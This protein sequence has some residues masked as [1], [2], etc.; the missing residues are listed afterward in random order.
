MYFFILGRNPA[1]SIAEI[2]AVLARE[3]VD[4]KID[5]YSSEVLLIEAKEDLSR[6]FRELGG[7][8]KFGKIINSKPVVEELVKSLPPNGKKAFFGFS[9]YKLDD[10]VA[11]SDLRQ[12]QKETQKLAMEIKKFLRAKGQSA[13]F[14]VSRER[15][16]SSVIVKTNKLLTTGAEFV[17]FI[18]TGSLF[19][20]PGLG[21]ARRFEMGNLVGQTLAVQEFEEY[22]FRDYGR[23]RRDILRG[24]LPPKIAKIMINLARV[25]YEATILDPFCGEG[26][27]L[28]EAAILGYKNLIGTDV[29]PEAVADA[30]SNLEWTAE[31]YKMNSQVNIF[32]ADVRNLPTSLQ[33]HS[34][35]RGTVGAI[36][37]EPF[38]GPLLRGSEKAEVIQKIKIELEEL[39]QKAFLSFSKI[40]KSDGKVVF[41]FPV[42]R[43]SRGLIFIDLQ[44]I[45]PREFKVQNSCGQSL[46][47]TSESHCEGKARGNHYKD[48]FTSFAM[49]SRG[50]IIW[51]RPDQKVLREIIVL[52]FETPH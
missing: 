49:T 46:R 29:D 50:G 41:I 37:T 23:P 38:L 31:Q 47:G 9:F 13:R 33:S 11:E 6:V 27:I 26:T 52:E 43:T 32:I 45:L 14:V 44:K 10:R 22:Q 7:S 24:M 36:V 42:W 25:S 48:C 18:S 1:L 16:L 21:I 20:G 12:R 39:Y 35:D 15:V 34:P 28:A 19:H 30:K 8:I 17:F 40:L 4:Y 3:R 2:L 51:Q 5:G